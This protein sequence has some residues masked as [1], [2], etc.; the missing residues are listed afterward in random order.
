MAGSLRLERVV[1]E[2][3]HLWAA[4]VFTGVLRDENGVAIGIGSRRH[5]AP[6][7]VADDA[8]GARLVVG[9]VQV[10]L[11]GLAVSIPAFAVRADTGEQAAPNAGSSSPTPWAGRG[12]DR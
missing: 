5:S 12:T 10:D 1:E 8:D 3:G 11:L 6:A 2:S 4:G 9:P 7:A